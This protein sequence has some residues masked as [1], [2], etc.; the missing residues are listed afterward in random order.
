[1]AAGLNHMIPSREKKRELEG[2][3]IADLKLTKNEKEML[4]QFF[5][6]V[7]SA[8]RQFF[9]NAI[10]HLNSFNE[11]NNAILHVYSLSFFSKRIVNHPQTTTGKYVGY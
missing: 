6:S 10:W 11:C 1:M 7:K 3:K 8:V 5:P 9:E 2:M 4:R